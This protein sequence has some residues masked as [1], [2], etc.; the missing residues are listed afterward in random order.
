MRIWLDTTSAISSAAGEHGFYALDSSG[1]CECNDECDPPVYFNPFQQIPPFHMSIS[2]EDIHS[3]I[4]LVLKHTNP[5]HMQPCGDNGQWLVCNPTTRGQIMVVDAEA[6]ALLRLFHIPG[7]F[8][9][10]SQKA[11]IPIARLAEFVKLF[12]GLGVLQDVN[13]SLFA[14]EQVRNATLTAWL[15]VTNACNL[16]CDY[17]YIQKSSEHMADDTARR[18]VDAVI[19]SAIRN[20][21]KNVKLKYAGGEASIRLP[22]ILA[23]HDYAALQANGHGLGLSASI[24]SNGVFLSQHMID[25]LKARHIGVMISLD[26]VGEYHDRQRPFLNGK[27]SF[28]YVDR[29]IALLLKNG[30]RPHINVTVSQRNLDGLISLI[31]YILERDLSFSLS[32]YRDNE[33]STHLQDLQFADTQM[34]E[35]MLDVFSYIEKHL[36]GR[37]LIGS[38][39]DKANM[40]APHQHTCGVG[41]NYLVIDP[42]GGVAKCHA[43]ITQTVTTIDADDPL[44]II[45]LDRSGI[46]A[47]PVEEKEGCRSCQWRYWCSGGCPML[48][49]RLTGRNDIKSPNCNIYQALFPAALRLEALRLLKYETPVIL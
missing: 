40:T 16:H 10:V 27:G 11:A 24:L 21:Y 25:Q 12:I 22:D 48:T 15:H 4:D 35:A 5:L 41:R 6:V 33:C 39:I 3:F 14:A 9:V 46:Q 34:I 30:L 18:S 19:R 38:L 8:Q 44:R 2:Q 23:L 43:A 47:V 32:Y 45:Q 42:H 31:G 17:C 13:Q 36:P 29:T 20:N 49:Y 26:G 7:E 37:R 28:R 1:E